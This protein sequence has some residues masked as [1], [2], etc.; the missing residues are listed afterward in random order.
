MLEASLSRTAWS[1]AG[2]GSMI[3]EGAVYLGMLTP[4]SVLM[5]VVKGVAEQ[6][7]MVWHEVVMVEV[8]VVLPW[9]FVP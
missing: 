1:T 8:A 4:E 5:V 6:A 2:K 9:L 3:M 7:V